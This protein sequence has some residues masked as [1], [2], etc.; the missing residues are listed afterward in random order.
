MAGKKMI[1]AEQARVI[2]EKSLV[3][4]ARGRKPVELYEPAKYILG[5]GGKRIRPVITLLSCNLFSENIKNAINPAVGLEVFH[6]Y[7]LVHDD[8]MDNALLRRGKDT[9]HALWGNNTAILSGDAMS[10]LAYELMLQS[11]V[12][13]LPSVLKTFTQTA[14]EVCEGQQYDMNFETLD[15]VSE[16]DYLEMIKLKTSVL[17]AGCMKIGALLGGASEAEA[18][19]LYQVGLN[20]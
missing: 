2:V 12:S 1:T 10:I 9:I 11:P 7:T 6:N 13:V 15:S 18:E 19:R 17:L 14:L 4:V 8:I 16:Q 5:L 3:N 20:A